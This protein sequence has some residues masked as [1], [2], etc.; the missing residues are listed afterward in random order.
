[1]SI[2]DA[3]RQRRILLSF[4]DNRRRLISFIAE[5]LRD[6]DT[7]GCFHAGQQRDLR[8]T[9]ET[10]SS[11]ASKFLSVASSVKTFPSKVSENP[12]I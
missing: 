5:D 10:Q 8:K 12:V 4:A 9:S 7:I 11:C 3:K 2:S 1:M 6:S